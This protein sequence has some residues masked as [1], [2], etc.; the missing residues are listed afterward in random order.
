[1]VI[2][3]DTGAL[4]ALERGDAKMRALAEEIHQAKIPAVTSACVIAQAWRPGSRNHAVARLLKSKGIEVIPLDANEGYKVGA[5]LER[6]RTTDI[7]DAHV[8]VIARPRNAIA[9]TSDPKDIS[10]LDPILRVVPI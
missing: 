7:V 1:M 2:V 4:I 6:S 5:L 8:A 10:R 3:L 9:V